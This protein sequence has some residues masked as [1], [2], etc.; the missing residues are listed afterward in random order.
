MFSIA[1]KRIGG[2]D[3]GYMRANPNDDVSKKE[4][5]DEDRKLNALFWGRYACS[6]VIP[7]SGEA[8]SSALRTPHSVKSPRQSCFDRTKR[9]AILSR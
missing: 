6:E 3:S 1:A 4:D 5:N 2:S 7:L 9:G 8:G